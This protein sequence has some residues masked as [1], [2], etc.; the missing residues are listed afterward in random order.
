MSPGRPRRSPPGNQPCNFL[1]ATICV[2]RQS[3]PLSLS[4]ADVPPARRRRVGR[5]CQVNSSPL[6]GAAALPPVYSRAA[7][8]RGVFFMSNWTVKSDFMSETLRPKYSNINIIQYHPNMQ[9][10]WEDAR[11]LSHPPLPRPPPPRQQGGNC[12]GR[13]TDLNT[14]DDKLKTRIIKN[15]RSAERSRQRKL[16]KMQELEEKIERLE[17]RTVE[18]LTRQQLA[19]LRAQHEQVMRRVTDQQTLMELEDEVGVTTG[20]VCPLGLCTMRDPVTAADGVSYER[21]HIERHIQCCQVCTPSDSFSSVAPVV[22]VG[23]AGKYR[24]I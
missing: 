1:A 21:V 23:C 18:T 4:A 24:M 3:M 5:H 8:R 2:R 20:F 16:S 7:G 10:A 13:A 12:Q 22:Q 6:L 17:G 11:D 19:E 14:V 15:R 9:P